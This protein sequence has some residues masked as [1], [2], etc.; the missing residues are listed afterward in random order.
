MTDQPLTSECLEQRRCELGISKPQ[1]AR[2]SRVSLAT[3]QRLLGG[4]ID[5]ATVANVRAVSSAL[6]V[7]LTASA[8]STSPEMQEQ[9]AT[10]KAEDIVAMIQGTSALEGQAVDSELRQQMVQRTVHELMA[11]SK[12]RLWST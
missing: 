3:V 8:A 2:R 12:R 5:N 1:L 4:Q 10:A 6:G 9:E 7:N 11:G